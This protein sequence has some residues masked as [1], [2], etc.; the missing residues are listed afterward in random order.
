MMKRP[1]ARGL[2]TD[3]PGAYDRHMQA[4]DAHDAQV[5]RVEQAEA[6]LCAAARDAD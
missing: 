1:G 2:P 5:R 4:L 3:V 6:A